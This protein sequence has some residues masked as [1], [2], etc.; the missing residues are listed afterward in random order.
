LERERVVRVEVV[1]F[2]LAVGAVVR[3]YGGF[4]LAKI[5]GIE[6]CSG[7]GSAMLGLDLMTIIMTGVASTHER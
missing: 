6:A 2:D 5:N 1:H 4:E 7:S 3:P